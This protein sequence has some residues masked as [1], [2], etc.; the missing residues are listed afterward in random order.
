MSSISIISNIDT[1][2]MQTV[3]GILSGVILL[4]MILMLIVAVNNFSPTNPTFPTWLQIIYKVSW[5]ILN[6][7]ALILII[8][9][10]WNIMKGNTGH[11]IVGVLFGV[12][13]FIAMWY[14]AG[15][16]Y[17]WRHENIPNGINKNYSFCI[18]A[19]SPFH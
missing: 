10:G 12:L 19:V 13:W 14:Q 6:G 8:L 3:I 17:N 1:V 4:L 7:C 2:K 5:W 18:E 16:N 15:I 11:G 9:G